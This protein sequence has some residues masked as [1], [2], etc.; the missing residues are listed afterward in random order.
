[1]TI[2]GCFVDLPSRRGV[3]WLTPTLKAEVTFLEIVA[4]RLRAAVWRGLATR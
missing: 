3:T 4:G 2:L 1:M